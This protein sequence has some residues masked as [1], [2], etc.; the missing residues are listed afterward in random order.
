M[1]DNKELIKIL[2]K[3]PENA[4]IYREADHGQT[5]EADP[6]VMVGVFLGKE[7]P[8]MCDGEINWLD[9]DEVAEDKLHL[10]NCI[11]IG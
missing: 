11:L 3:L 4:K 8:Y 9:P 10:I 6:G 1:M 5:P 2:A 7:F